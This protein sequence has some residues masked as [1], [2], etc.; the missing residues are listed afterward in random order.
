LAKRAIEGIKTDKAYAG[1]AFEEYLSTFSA[2]LDRL[3]ITDKSGELDDQVV[4]KIDAFEASRNEFIQVLTAFVQYGQLG[5]SF[6]ALQR[7][8]ESVLA[9]YENPE[10]QSSYLVDEFDHFKFIGHELFLYVLATCLRAQ[11]FTSATTML[12]QQYYL[13]SRTRSSGSSVSSFTVFRE[14]MNSLVRR[15][16]RLVLRRISLRADILEKR[17]KSSSL[18][19]QAVM[20]AD[21]ICFMRAELDTN[22]TYDRWWPETL[23]Y[24]RHNY[25]AFEVF[26]RAASNA[27]LNKLLL[28]LGVSTLDPVKT[29]LEEYASGTRKLPSWDFHSFNPATLMAFDRLGTNA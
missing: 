14:H 25:G 18:P 29:K 4:L 17:S 16:Q 26:A 24:S 12:S 1:G 7:F 15:N 5:S 10:G 23:L 28:L 19:F 27:H 20:Q 8:L 9:L 21:F 22:L 6:L 13:T 3:R 11:D 2:N